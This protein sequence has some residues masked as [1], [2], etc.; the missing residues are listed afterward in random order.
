MYRRCDEVMEAIIGMTGRQLLLVPVRLD[1]VD[2]AL[3]SA[4]VLVREIKASGI[5]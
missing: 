3:S 1:E 5:G 4:L 2:R